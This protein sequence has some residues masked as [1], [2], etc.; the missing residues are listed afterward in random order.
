MTDRLPLIQVSVEVKKLLDE[1]GGKRDT[2]ND[3]VSKLLDLEK[4]KR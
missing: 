3:I 2:Y 1:L 4:S